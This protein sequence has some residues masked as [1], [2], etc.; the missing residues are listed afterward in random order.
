MDDA[1][2]GTAK[3]KGAL[4][5]YQVMAIVTGVF[6]LLVTAGMILKYVL[7]VTNEG[8]LE[9]TSVIA[10]THGF[11]YMA[12][13]V[14]CAD[15]WTRARWGWGRLGVLI[16]GGV[17]PGLSFVVERRITREFAAAVAP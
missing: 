2:M 15:L 13:L 17:V 1:G 16:L 9:V 3:T 6:L 4:R 14:T 7:Q 8:V 5:R 11:I 12:Y 10:M